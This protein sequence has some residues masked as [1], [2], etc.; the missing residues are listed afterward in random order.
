[1]SRLKKVLIANRGEI[2]VRI[3]RGC[4][5]LGIP[6]AVVYSTADRMSRAVRLADE[7]I[8]IGPPEARLSYLDIDKILDAA[9]DCGADAIH[10]GY[11]FLSENAEFARRV[12]DAGLVFVGPSAE[13]IDAMGDK[14]SS[15]KLMAEAGVPVIPGIERESFDEKSLAAA[16]EE[17]GYP[18]ML[19]ATAGGGGKGIRI[20]HELADLWP[21]Y[22]RSVGESEKAFG[23]GTVFLEKA[24]VGPHHIEMQIFG[25]SHGNHV[26]LF[27]R[28]CSIQRRHQKVVE[29]A[30]S[31]FMTPELQARMAEA[32]ILAAKAI[33]YQNAGTVEFLVDAQRDFYFLEVNTRLQVEHPITEETTGIDMVREQ[34][35]VASGEP[36]SFTQADLEQRGH[37]IEARICA[38]DPDNGYLPAVGSVEGL[39]LPAG[40]G[41]RIDSALT[42]GLEVSLH[43]DPMLA[44]L[45]TYG[46]DRDEAIARMKQALTE[47]KIAGVKTNIPFLG[48]IIRHPAF[49]SG[50]YDTG[51]LE[52][53]VKPEMRREQLE[54]SLIA[55]ALQRHTGGGEA[56]VRTSQGADRGGAWRNYARM[57][58][59][60]RL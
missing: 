24:I 33:D 31:P 59:V 53:F 41:V 1:M 2:A 4:H 35:L 58:G 57:R 7:A 18:V 15:R 46:A 52:D 16:A 54:A 49:V 51:F 38:E 3:I 26:H 36:L 37:A 23:N 17:I 25:D 8:C 13:S 22:Q 39:T 56:R 34:L 48:D 50:D 19:K 47:L 29:E 40:G 30:P 5:S 27:E 60:R 55:A 44:K 20:V 12:R 42:P 45:V 32:A 28:E 14:I 6:C 10:P 43:Y 9:A 21:S 11:G